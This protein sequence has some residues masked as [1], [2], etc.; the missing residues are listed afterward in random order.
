MRDIKIFKLSAA[1][2]V[3]ICVI[4]NLVALLIT[5]KNYTPLENKNVSSESARIIGGVSSKSNEFPF[6]AVVKI[7]H[8][9]FIYTCGSTILSDK[10][11]VT[12]AH[13][14]Y[15]QS[16]KIRPNNTRIG[17]GSRNIKEVKVLEPLR[18]HVHP[19]YIADKNVTIFT[20]SCV[21]KKK[22]KESLTFGPGLQT[23]KIDLRK[24]EENT[25]VTALGWGI[26]SN[27]STLPSQELMETS[28]F[29]QK[30][31]EC[32]K[33]RPNFTSNNLDY[34]CAANGVQGKDTCY[35]DSGA[36]IIRTQKPL[37]AYSVLGLTSYGDIIGNVD[38]LKKPKCADPK[39]FGFYTHIGYYIYF[40][41]NVTGIPFE[42]LALDSAAENSQI[43]TEF[44]TE[45]KADVLS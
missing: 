24:I 20:F 39:G 11:L 29:I 21:Q 18:F 43:I 14:V 33:V 2:V 12:A 27:E 5:I 26:T 37:N 15:I 6:A 31:Q 19:K 34:I 44:D 17:L 3:G 30:P 23:A 22:L 32:S 40:I 35:G 41:S 13:C 28:L 38:M 36:P 9:K 25:E 45:T 1:F 8:E 7:S 10:F 4:A 42:T 16:Q